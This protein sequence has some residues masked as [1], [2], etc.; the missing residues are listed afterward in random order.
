MIRFCG[1]ALAVP[2]A[3]LFVPAPRSVLP[4]FGSAW[5]PQTPT[6]GTAPAFARAAHSTM[7]S[8]WEFGEDV[9]ARSPEL[10][11]E[12][13]PCRSDNYAPIIHDAATGATAVVDSPDAAAITERLVA[14]GWHLTHILNTHHHG[15]HTS[16]NERTIFRARAFEP[17]ACDT[18]AML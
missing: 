2:T 3:R 13:V 15:D 16:G 11:V 9:L 7:R 6:L 5:R 12:M 10:E 4:L 18:R 14:K 1:A 8:H 17:L